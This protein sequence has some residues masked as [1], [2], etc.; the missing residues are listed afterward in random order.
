MSVLEKEEAT[1][2]LQSEIEYFKPVNDNSLEQNQLEEVNE[3]I[4]F[5][6]EDIEHSNA[7][8]ARF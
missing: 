5:D 4:I 8:L 2:I 1:D 6:D 3:N 7:E